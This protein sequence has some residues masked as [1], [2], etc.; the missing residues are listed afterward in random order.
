MFEDLER[1]LDAFERQEVVEVT[2]DP[3]LEHFSL[4][5]D[6]GATMQQFTPA[7]SSVHVRRTKETYRFL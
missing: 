1:Q 3:R 2:V 6:H 5:C 4:L 7:P